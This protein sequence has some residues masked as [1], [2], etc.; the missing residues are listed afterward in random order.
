MSSLWCYL[1]MCTVTASSSS[2]SSEVTWG[3]CHSALSAYITCAPLSQPLTPLVHQ[4]LHVTELSYGSVLHRRRQNGGVQERL[5]EG[6]WGRLEEKQVL[7]WTQT[8]IHV[9]HTVGWVIALGTALWTKQNGERHLQRGA[10]EC[11][12]GLESIIQSH[13]GKNKQA[14]KQKKNPTTLVSAESPAANGRKRHQWQTGGGAEC[15]NRNCT[16]L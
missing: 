4:R 7:R 16:E 1:V 15:L 13:R 14:N 9:F 12:R 10:V 6:Q 3:G 8:A 11:D 5:Q 2:S